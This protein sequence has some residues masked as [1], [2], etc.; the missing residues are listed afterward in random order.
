MVL[1]REERLPL[2][3]PACGQERGVGDDQDPGL[4]T[5]SLRLPPGPA[6]ILRYVVRSEQGTVAFSETSP[7]QPRAFFKVATLT[8][9]SPRAPAVCRGRG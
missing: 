2:T 4:A 6:A 9:P 1:T 8:R 7:G 5:R 3:T